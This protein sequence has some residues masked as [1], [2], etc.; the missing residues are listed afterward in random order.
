MC[1]YHM[2]SSMYG[3][4]LAWTPHELLPGSK[5]RLGRLSFMQ[6][7]QRDSSSLFA[8]ESD[9]EFNWILASGEVFSRP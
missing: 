6:K 9:L 5:I 3:I 1:F 4:Q 2:V 8:L 7:M